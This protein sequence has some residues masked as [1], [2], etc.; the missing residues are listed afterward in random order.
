MAKLKLLIIS[1]SIRRDIQEPLRYFDKFD[2]WH[3][4]LSAPYGDYSQ[5]ELARLKNV[6]K[7]NLDNLKEEIKKLSPDIVQ[8]TEPFGSRKSLLAAR[9][10]YLAVRGEKKIKFIVPILEN[11]PINER[12]SS[13]QRIILRLFVP[14]YF[15]RVD[16]FFPL[17]KR[18]VENIKYYCRNA[19]MS[20]DYI[21]GI[22]GVDTK[23]FKPVAKK[24]DNKVVYVGRFVY[25]KGI[26]FLL[27]GFRLAL[28]TNPN[29]ELCL[30]GSGEY[31]KDI[32]EIISRYSLKKKIFIMGYASREQLPEIFSSAS[33]AVYPSITVK[34]W[35]EQVGTVNFQ[36]L[37]CST[38][39]ITTRSGA[40]PEYIKEG[41]GAILVKEKDSK[42]I[43]EA[44]VKYFKSEDLRKKLI[45]RARKFV[46]RYEISGT[47]KAAQRRIE[48]LLNE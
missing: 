32:R 26:S 48:E 3:F 2:V 6:K 37:A 31:E 11:R 36:A 23:I 17:N 47:I 35:E 25:E 29:L 33:I 44:L 8:G 46:M 45:A 5:E 13:L 19:K 18:A 39:I 43:A 34:K 27:E 21:W 38:P 16:L 4:Y 28:E 30:Y 10:I 42:A 1:E 7:V 20:E 40:I 24:E 41:E 15:K 22:W 14:R 9:S 12:F